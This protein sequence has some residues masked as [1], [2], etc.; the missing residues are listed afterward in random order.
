MAGL[1]RITAPSTEPVSS[2]EAKLWT[3]QSGSGDDDIFT[4]LIQSAREMTEDYCQRA[5][6]T[7]TWE[8]MIDAIPDNGDA[9]DWKIRYNWPLSL[10][11][12]TGTGD[13]IEI[14]RPPLIAIS[15][16]KY[17]N[18]ANTEATF[19]AASYTTDTWGIGQRGRVYLNTGYSW[20]T[21]LRDRN[22][23]LITFSAGYGAAA[24]VPAAVKVA[25]RQIIEATYDERGGAIA[26][27]ETAKNLLAPY[28]I[29]SI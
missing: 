1:K 11:A 26:F 13:Y 29:V 23:I 21:D 8:Y 9:D 19:A 7:Q 5:W 20:P 22:A 28:R 3:K 12:P 27:P 16:I 14:P 15:S 25:M 10:P 6:I 2:T 17:Y 18:S 4:A 24:A